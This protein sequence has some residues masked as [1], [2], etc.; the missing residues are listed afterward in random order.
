[1]FY[2]FALKKKLA[3]KNINLEIKFLQPRKF[4]L[5]IILEKPSSQ[6]LN[7]KDYK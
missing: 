2:Y 3:S 7:Y 4:L 5:L 6:Y 1:M